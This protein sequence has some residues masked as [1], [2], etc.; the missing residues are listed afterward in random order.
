MCR[1]WKYYFD[2]F[3]FDRP[4]ERWNLLKCGTCQLL[5]VVE[6]K[7]QHTHTHVFYDDSFAGR[8]WEHAS[9]YARCTSKYILHYLYIHIC[10]YDIEWIIGLFCVVHCVYEV[11]WSY[12]YTEH[13]IIIILLFSIHI[14]TKWRYKWD[15]YFFNNIVI[16]FEHHFASINEQKTERKKT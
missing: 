11:H 9:A 16:D 13:I 4:N 1:R 15:Y 2:V 10:I 5:C 7:Q 3:T 12:A 8:V 6:Y 14:H